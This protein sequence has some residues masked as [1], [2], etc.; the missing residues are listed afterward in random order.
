MPTPVVWFCPKCHVT[1]PNPIRGAFQL[2]EGSRVIVT[3][4]GCGR[5]TNI[6]PLFREKAK[7]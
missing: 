3:C 4:R 2:G 5:E 7:V 6:A 1:N